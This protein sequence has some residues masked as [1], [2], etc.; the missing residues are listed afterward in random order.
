MASYR[1][2]ILF[3]LFIALPFFPDVFYLSL[4]VI[5]ASIIDLDHPMRERNLSL[6][7]FFA[8]LLTGI[9]YL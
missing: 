9:L 1:K 8:L 5:G 7:A 4:A 6:V 2:H 3:S